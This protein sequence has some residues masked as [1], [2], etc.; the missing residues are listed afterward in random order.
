MKINSSNDGEKSFSRRSSGLSRSPED[1]AGT[2][3]IYRKAW[4]TALRI[5][6]D[7]AHSVYE[8]RVK[9]RRRFDTGTAEKVLADLDRSGY[10]NDLEFSQEYARQRFNR[11]PRA[12]FMV[13]TELHRKGVDKEIAAQAVAFALAEGNSTERC[14]ALNA[15]RK[16]LLS[17]REKDEAELKLKLFRFLSR[18][19]FNQEIALWAIEQSLASSPET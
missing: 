9:L 10:L 1:R 17:L 13:V 3:E 14:L 18:R 11:S 2:Q 8:L 12:S 19:G 16:K 4:R 5:L 15:A 7:R 6:A